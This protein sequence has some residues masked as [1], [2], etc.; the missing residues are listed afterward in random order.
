MEYID[1]KIK[2]YEQELNQQDAIEKQ[3]ETKKKDRLPKQKKG[4]L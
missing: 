2:E 4:Q 1:T 3:E